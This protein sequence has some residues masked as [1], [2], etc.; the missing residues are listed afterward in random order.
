MSVHRNIIGLLE[1]INT[2]NYYR[3][4]YSYSIDI[5]PD[6]VKYAKVLDIFRGSTSERDYPPDHIISDDHTRIWRHNEYIIVVDPQSF[7][8]AFA[9]I[10][11]ITREE[12]NM[13]DNKQY[14]DE[15]DV[16]IMDA[17]NYDAEQQHRA[18]INADMD[19]MIESFGRARMDES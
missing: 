1:E 6:Y 19:D 18:H 5:M 12:I 9:E 7:L 3:N 15:D 4:D 2:W 16:R 14:E 11:S 8:Y 17:A 13:M 10:P